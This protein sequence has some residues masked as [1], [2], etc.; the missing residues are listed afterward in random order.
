MQHR[1]T[2]RKRAQ[3]QKV[4]RHP[5][6][7]KRSPT[8]R[9][10]RATARCRSAARSAPPAPHA[11]PRHRHRRTRR[12]REPSCST[13]IRAS[14]RHALNRSFALLATMRATSSPCCWSHRSHRPHTTRTRRT[15][16]AA[17]AHASALVDAAHAH[18]R[19]RTA[20]VEQTLERLS[21]LFAH[22]D[23]LVAATC[24]QARPH[25]L[26]IAGIARLKRAGGAHRGARARSPRT[27]TRPPQAGRLE[28]NA[29]R[30]ARLGALQHAT[31]RLR[32]L[33]QRSWRT[34][35][36]TLSTSASTPTM[37]RLPMR[38]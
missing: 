34:R 10:T 23:H 5:R 29:P 37:L 17:S 35:I 38:R 12:K 28:G 6:M 20:L 26:R 7:A 15:P 25:K 27:S 3:I 4:P 21:H 19:R 32:T 24:G 14:L 18:H 1:K 11:H 16:S 22:D 13:S 33:A 36:A 30:R 9:P 8:L 2:A 31:L